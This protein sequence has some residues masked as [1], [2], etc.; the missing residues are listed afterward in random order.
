MEREL[1]LTPS[2][3][4]APE[5]P[6]AE[7]SSPSD[8]LPLA[9][10]SSELGAPG[11]RKGKDLL[12]GAVLGLKRKV[13]VGPVKPAHEDF[14]PLIIKK[15]RDDLIPGFGICGGGKGGKGHV[16]CPP[17]SPDLKVIGAKIMAPLA[18]AMR[19]VHGDLGNPGAL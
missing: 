2:P 12:A 4:D 10:A 9:E 8:S 18:D 14:R 5:P 11:G 7:L 19:F 17:K 16:Q 3:P 1:E 13:D 6:S 15:A